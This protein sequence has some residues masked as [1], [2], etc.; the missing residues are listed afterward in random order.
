MLADPGA[1][2][3]RH[4][5]SQ[6]DGVNRE[7]SRQKHCRVTKAESQPEVAQLD[8]LNHGFKPRRRDAKIAGPQ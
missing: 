6:D 5:Y 4:H 1:V 8:D 2:F 3:D 7:E